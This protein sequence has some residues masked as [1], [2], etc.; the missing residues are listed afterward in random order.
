[1]VKVIDPCRI[2]RKLV[3]LRPC[4]RLGIKAHT[5]N[6]TTQEAEAEGS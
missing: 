2:V 3:S 1:M 6:P 5:Y 4:V